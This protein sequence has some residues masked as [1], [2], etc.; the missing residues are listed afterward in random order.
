MGQTSV[1][2]Q[3]AEKNA[4]QKKKKEKKSKLDFQKGHSGQRTWKKQM[5][6]KKNLK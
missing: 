3:I 2:Q 4:G 1:L 6:K 5:R